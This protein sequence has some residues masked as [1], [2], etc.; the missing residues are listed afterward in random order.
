V[1]FA[2][3]EDRF[4]EV[5]GPDP[6]Q[7]EALRR[8]SEGLEGGALWWWAA[9]S[10]AELGAVRDRFRAC[11]V[12]VG[13]IEPGERVRPDGER[14]AWETFDPAPVFAPALPFVIRWQDG[15]PLHGLPARCSLES[16]RLVHP[17]PAALSV[18]LDGVG[19]S[20]AVTVVSGD[21]PGV[22]AAVVGPRG[23]LELSTPVALRR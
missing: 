12:D 15:P 17:D 9:R 14:L 11:G 2:M 21:A 5:L 18:I 13:P 23:R 22:R 1:I 20:G 10:E 16:L 6:E 8:S 4:L 19:L 7:P 3:D